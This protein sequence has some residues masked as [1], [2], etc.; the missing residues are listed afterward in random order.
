MGSIIKVN[1]YKDFGNNAI[2]TS[3]GSGNVTINA[4][5]MKSTPSF[6]AF[7]S[8][9]QSISDNTSTK[10]QFDSETFDTDNT[11][12]NSTNYRFTPGV[13][14]KYFVFT[15]ICCTASVGNTLNY[16]GVVMKKNGSSEIARNSVDPDDSYRHNQ[17]YPYFATIV[18]M[19]TTDYIEIFAQID[20]ASGTPQI[21][22]GTNQT[23]FGAYKLIGA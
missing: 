6:R 1:E 19:N 8:S 3:D 9:T 10:V 15:Q 22:D 11:F 7:R 5:A 4:A 13:S 18:E 21:G 2:M 23:Y 14:G 17:A 12:D 20:V 16:A